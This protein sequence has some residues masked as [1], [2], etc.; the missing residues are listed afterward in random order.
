MRV[1]WSTVLSLALMLG[2]ISSSMA[3]YSEDVFG[4][5][6]LSGYKKEISMDLQGASL[7]DV[8]KV[9]SQQTGLSFVSSDN[10]ADRRLTLYLEKVPLK[11]AMDSIFLA[12]KLEYEFYPESNI[13]I[14]KE[15]IVPEE[16]RLETRIYE[17]KHAVVPSA[18]L[19][20]EIDTV[21]GAESE[22]GT[23]GGYQESGDDGPVEG[24]GILG[25][26]QAVL[27]EFGVVGEDARTNSLIVRD[28]P[29]MFNEIESVIA[30]L[31]V[32]LPKVMIEVEIVDVS[33]ATG[34]KIG[35]YWGQGLS[36]A[37]SLRGAVRET[38]FPWS[39]GDMPGAPNIVRA[40]EGEVTSEDSDGETS[41][42]T[43]T[44]Q[45]LGKSAIELGQLGF[46]DLTAVM[47][48]LATDGTSKFLA[49]PRIM[50]LSGMTAEINLVSN[51][52]ITAEATTSTD[53]GNTTTS[54]SIQREDVGTMLRVTPQVSGATG[55]IT[56][57]VEPT[58]SNAVADSKFTTSNNIANKVQK[59]ESR[60]V[61]R[62][63]SNET[64]MIG[65]LL[66]K[67][68]AEIETKVPLLGDLPILG[69]LFRHTNVSEEE[70]ELLVF[71]TPKIVEES[72]S[73]RPIVAKGYAPLEREQSMGK[74]GNN[75]NNA[76]ARF[77]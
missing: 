14:I 27:S 24:S 30:R 25:A 35:V 4:D 45:Q 6:L 34:D 15:A 71:L 63:K 2:P 55:E 48:F 74:R 53:S 69:R 7:V 56:L 58:V 13:F 18:T 10:V 39:F 38:A 65:G 20:A 49:R 64:L 60:Q 50:T 76:L 77:E 75:I 32:A 9:L 1:L 19:Q 31:D 68:T 70:R 23:D 67:D 73:V 26:V 36:M 66:K 54:W 5:Y 43:G 37:V 29:E 51:E 17:L 22:S 8:L 3:Y 44:E 11:D 61:V 41:T 47:Q 16:K 12:N 21:T 59:R 42:V 28:L 40:F 33:K 72:G 62:I 57:V 52:A 46:G